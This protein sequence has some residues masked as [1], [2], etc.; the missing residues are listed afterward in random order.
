MTLEASPYHH[1]LTGALVGCSVMLKSTSSC[2]LLMFPSFLAFSL[3]LTFLYF[4]KKVAKWN[5]TSQTPAVPEMK[6]FVIFF[7]PQKM[8]QNISMVWMCM[9]RQ[10]KR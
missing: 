4:I 5:N 1:S 3:C 2:F 6:G 10:Y 8:W 9:K 7:S